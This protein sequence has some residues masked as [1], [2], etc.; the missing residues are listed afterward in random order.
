MELGYNNNP[1]LDECWDGEDKGSRR[2][3]INFSSS[4]FSSSGEERE[5]ASSLDRS[6]AERRDIHS[7]LCLPRCVC[8]AE[9]VCLSL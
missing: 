2:G 4:A 3:I 7:P 6:R 1:G 5:T 8:K 9:A